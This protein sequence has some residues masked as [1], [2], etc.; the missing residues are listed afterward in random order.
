MYPLG[1]LG[2]PQGGTVL[3]NAAEYVRDRWE[4]FVAL[5]PA[6]IDLQHRAAEAR[7]R[8]NQ[9][10]KT[11]EADAARAVIVELGKLNVTHGK[12]V[13]HFSELAPYVGLGAVAV[14]VALA[15]AFS[16]AAIAMLWFFRKMDIQ[17]KA[18]GLLEAG[19]LS[20]EGFLQM[21]KEAGKNP[22]GETL[23]FAKLALWAFLGW[24]AL[25]ALTTFQGPRRNPPLVIF[26]N[27]PEVLSEDVVFLQ[28]VHAEDGEVYRHEFDGDVMAEALP[29][30]GLLIS[31]PTRP[32]WGE[33]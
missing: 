20:E 11:R 29:D 8:Y 19:V 15:A 3:S 18:L 14:P 23:G 26:G 30:G 32:V 27:P 5:T 25:Q 9:E 4:A 28:Y 31:H 21:N 16:T 7:Y 22:L 12:I 24:V 6:I 33:F 13:D 1:E 2:A 10:G 17:E